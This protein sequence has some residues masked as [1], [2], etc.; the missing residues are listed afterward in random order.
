MTLS[1]M[2]NPPLITFAVICKNEAANICRCLDSIILEAV[3]W[4]AEILVIDSFSTDSTVKL[5]KRYPVTI[6]QLGRDWPHSPAAGRYTAVRRARGSFLL[7][8]DGDMELLPGFLKAALEQLHSDPSVVAV[9]GRLHNFHT[10]NGEKFYISS[11]FASCTD[12]R[13]TYVDS[14]MPLPIEV[15]AGSALFRLQAVREAGNFHPFLKAEEEYEISKRIRGR[16]GQILYLP[17]DAANHYGYQSDPIKEA[18]RRLKQGLVRGVGQMARI[19]FQ[20]GYG[21]TY[22]LRFYQHLIV[23]LFFLFFI[24]A[25]LLV[26]YYPLAFLFWLGVFSMLL[27]IYWRKK[28]NFK[29]GLAAFLVKGLIGIEILRGILHSVPKKEDYP[30]SVAIMSGCQSKEVGMR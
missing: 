24:P 20:E 4:E 1:K 30:T 18:F 12:N 5:A 26:W 17:V 21:L 16:G 15:A 22:L 8:I 13:T 23:G 7:L 2:S 9:R 29:A 14:S 25:L 11:K 19:A 6:V 28:H 10:I 27:G 3:K